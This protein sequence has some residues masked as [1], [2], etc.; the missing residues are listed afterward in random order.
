MLIK[1]VR[2]K[3]IRSYINETIVFPEGSVLLSGDIGSGKSTIFLA[4]EFALFGIKA[5]EL[6]GES[7]IRHGTKEGSVEIRLLIDK[8]DVT[9]KRTL[10]RTGDSVKQD[11]GHDSCYIIIDGIKTE[12]TPVELKARVFSLLGYPSAILGKSKDLIYRYTVYTPQEEMKRILTED[13]EVRLDTLRRVFDI[14]KYKEIRENIQ[15]YAKELK[16]RQRE[17]EGRIY[18]LDEKKSQLENEKAELKTLQLGL[19]EI[20]PQLENVKNEISS[21]RKLLD[22]Y[23]IKITELEKAKR[24]LAVLQ[25]EIKNKLERRRQVAQEI[26]ALEKRISIDSAVE[27]PDLKKIRNEINVS[28][29]IIDETDANIRQ[30]SARIA[31]LKSNERSSLDIIEKI[32]N[33]DVCPL[34]KQVVSPEHKEAVCAA[35]K[36]NI[37]KIQSDISAL[38]LEHNQLLSKKECEKARLR[39]LRQDENLAVA[40]LERI[41]NIKSIQERMLTLQKESEDLRGQLKVLNKNEAEARHHIEA[42]LDAEER[43]LSVE[44]EINELLES[45]KLLEIRKEGL[46]VKISRINAQIELLSREIK[47]KEIAKAKYATITTVL[48]WFLDNF[49]GL[50]YTLEKHVMTRIY[51]EF[52]EL[53]SGWVNLLIDDETLSVRLDDEFT[54]VVVQNG[55][56]TDFAS[57]SG[58]EKT[59]IALS[60]R[61]ALN[62][63]I[64]DMVGSIR[65]RSIIML[66]EPTDGFSTEQLEKIRDV[67]MELKM[68]QV[69]IVSH[70]PPVEGFVDQVIRIEKKN[71]IS[72][73]SE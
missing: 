30:H 3:N 27:M 57:L 1:S 22:D 28:E 20:A 16:S 37:D 72:R 39:K 35:E 63:V 70:E 54:P 71:H 12:L 24:N 55:Y 40:Q 25:T 29:K 17:L 15:E 52:N 53:F 58:G 42:M 34:C 61:L 8:Q 56:E 45:E 68:Q 66:D 67:L 5:G 32:N 62:K 44:K 9:I 33:L 60:Y 73:V 59:S 43:F 31:V 23:K 6:S 26:E 46:S 10:K 65:T 4:I 38:N 47:D 11:S 18:D 64:N 50:T 2:L 14:D 21:K 69:I 51:R 41:K 36:R 19:D 13:K 49:I 7:L 48:R